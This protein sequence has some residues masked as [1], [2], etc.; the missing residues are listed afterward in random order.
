M[1]AL[2]RELPEACDNTLLVAERCDV[3]L[4]EGANLM[5]RFPVPDGESEESWLVQEVERGLA[6]RFPAGVPD[7]HRAQADYEVGVIC[8]M[9]FPGYFLVVADLVRHAKDSGIRVGPGR[10]A[11]AGCLAALV[12]WSTELGP[13]ENRLLFEWYLNPER[14]SRE[15]IDGDLVE[16]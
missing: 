8:R 9:G 12:L 2:W 7:A 1:R 16:R 11:A 6:R 4:A 3:T 5:P 10:G 15:D 14:V 13:I